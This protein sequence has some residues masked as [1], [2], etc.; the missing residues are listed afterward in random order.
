MYINLFFKTAQSALK[1]TR[2]ST[3]LQSD[4]Q[5]VKEADQGQKVIQETD[6][7]LEASSP[8]SS[9]WPLNSNSSGQTPFTLLSPASFNL[10]ISTQPTST[11]DIQQNASFTVVRSSPLNTSAKSQSERC[12]FRTCSPF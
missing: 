11:T 2:E 3:T 1:S 5:P 4:Q 7:K 6:Q 8:A 12:V 10:P 9:Q